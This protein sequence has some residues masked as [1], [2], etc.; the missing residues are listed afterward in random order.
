MDVCPSKLLEMR[1]LALQNQRDVRSRDMVKPL[2][3][4]DF[5]PFGHVRVMVFYC[6]RGRKPDLKICVSGE[7]TLTHKSS[8]DFTATS[9]LLSAKSFMLSKA[10]LRQS[11]K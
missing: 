5:S 1:D 2:Y 10:S 7:R 9:H 11:C 4:L 8:Q 3:N 6:L